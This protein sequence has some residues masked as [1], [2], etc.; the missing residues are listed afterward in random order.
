MSYY[1]LE[2]KKTPQYATCDKCGDRYVMYSGRY[3]QRR[4][5][6]CH[7]WVDGFCYDCKEVY[8]SDS[9]AGCYH[10]SENSECCVCIIS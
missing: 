2:E 9:H 6:R 4:S 8:S 5:C 3:S 7:K 1:W 10:V